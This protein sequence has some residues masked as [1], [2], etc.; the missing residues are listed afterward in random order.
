M[1]CCSAHLCIGE[2]QLPVDD[3]VVDCVLSRVFICDSDLIKLAEKRQHVIE[4]FCERLVTK[5]LENELN[6]VTAISRSPSDILQ[7][8]VI[9]LLLDTL[10]R[11]VCRRSHEQVAE[12][13]SDIELM[14]SLGLPERFGSKKDEI[15]RK[16]KKHRNGARHRRII[17]RHEQREEGNEESMLAVKDDALF[18]PEECSAVANSVGESSPTTT[19]VNNPNDQCLSYVRLKSWVKKFGSQLSEHGKQEIFASLGEF[20]QPDVSLPFALSFLDRIVTK[21]IE[22]YPDFTSDHLSTWEEMWVKHCEF[23]FE[24]FCKCAVTSTEE[25]TSDSTAN[26]S[27]GICTEDASFA[28]VSGSDDAPEEYPIE[29]SSTLVDVEVPEKVV[30]LPPSSHSDR[31]IRQLKK[32]QRRLKKLNFVLGKSDVESVVKML[33][34]HGTD[35]LSL[36]GSTTVG[37]FGKMP[38]SKRRLWSS[39]FRFDPLMDSAL[40]AQRSIVRRS[41]RKYWMQRYRLFSKFDDGILMDEEGWYSVTP[42]RISEHIAERCQCD[43]VMDAFCGVGGNAIQFAKYCSHGT[44]WRSYK[45]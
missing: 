16:R 20:Q 35:D 9:S 45:L 41:L 1:V 40:L 4:L 22:N 13:S 28:P 3:H 25:T 11:T 23:T 18:L 43:V 14:K 6:P 38:L 36:D 37:D 44:L 8:V 26:S 10:V 17:S 15:Y 19:A 12:N 30:S 42:E 39:G 34:D 24:M 2:V 21:I 27:C 29:R 5:V 31:R 33:V 7:E 32:A